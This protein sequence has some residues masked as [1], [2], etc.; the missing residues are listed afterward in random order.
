[1]DRTLERKGKKTSLAGQAACKR[2]Q[3]KHKAGISCVCVPGEGA[4]VADQSAGIQNNK[5]MQKSVHNTQKLHTTQKV[6][7]RKDSRCAIF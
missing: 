6:P 2:K 1:M 3:G 4:K 7:N 5:A